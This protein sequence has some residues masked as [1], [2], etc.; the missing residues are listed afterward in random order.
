MCLFLS[1]LSA[2]SQ[3]S[4]E[5]QID[6]SLS[7]RLRVDLLFVIRSLSFFIPPL[8]LL[9]RSK[10][11]YA[12]TD[13]WDFECLHLALEMLCSAILKLE[14]IDSVNI[15][16]FSVLLALLFPSESQQPFP[17]V[18]LSITFL[19]KDFWQLI[20]SSGP[21]VLILPLEH[22]CYLFFFFFF[23][24]CK[25]SSVSQIGLSDGASL[26]LGQKI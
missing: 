1:R 21:T 9:S 24:L 23:V 25:G 2:G 3:M 4:R 17:V 18:I 12:W 11:C 16:L 7:L 15:D 20:T 10:F 6:M 14:E 22:F 19:L 26:S 8:P 5:E 13:S